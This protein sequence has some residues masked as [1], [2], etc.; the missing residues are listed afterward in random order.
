MNI[1]DEICRFLNASAPRL[2]VFRISDAHLTDECAAAQV[3]DYADLAEDD[4]V[5]SSDSLR[6][7]RKASDGDAVYLVDAEIKTYPSRYLAKRIAKI[8]ADGLG[9]DF[10]VFSAKFYEPKATIC[11]FA[12]DL[13]VY[14]AAA[15]KS[16]AYDDI[17]I[18]S[19]RCC[20]L[21][22]QAMNVK[23]DVAGRL[24]IVVMF[25]SRDLVDDVLSVDVLKKMIEAGD[26]L[27]YDYIA[28]SPSRS[29]ESI[30]FIISF[31]A[32]WQEDDIEIEDKLYH[33]AQ[34]SSKDKILKHGLNPHGDD[35]QSIEKKLEASKT[36]HGMSNI[37][38]PH[39]VYL[40]NGLDM[41]VIK[42]FLRQAGRM[43]KTYD[44][45]LRQ[46]VMSKDFCLI[47]VD[48]DKLKH[49]KLYRDNNFEN[50]GSCKPIALYTYSNIPPDALKLK[51][52]LHL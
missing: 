18:D 51:T 12:N 8:M 23:D 48:R 42:S 30:S 26:S 19:P 22:M 36:V 28:Y 35:R 32:K 31:E 6:A 25:P 43:S 44:K 40:F 38:H 47:E 5:F 21:K 24:H 39:R 20:Y 11:S 16:F 34:L 1:P 33:V 4:L 14:D 52:I 9:M 49:L 27:G 46:L 2:E 3:L 10:C 13:M 45:G 15:R 50:N 29:R 37:I 41:P 17:K 7:M